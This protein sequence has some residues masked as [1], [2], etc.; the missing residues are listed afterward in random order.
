MYK[1]TPKNTSM[2]SPQLCCH[3]E[4]VTINWPQLLLNYDLLNPRKSANPIL[5][6]EEMKDVLILIDAWGLQFTTVIIDSFIVK[7]CQL[8]AKMAKKPLRIQE[9]TWYVYQDVEALNRF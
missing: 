2:R 3:N 1:D 5:S 7:M 4:D 6:V 8:V 9:A